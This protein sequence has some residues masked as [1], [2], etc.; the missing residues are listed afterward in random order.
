MFG[1]KNMIDISDF[2]CAQRT[3]VAKAEN[4]SQQNV[5]EYRF[6]TQIKLFVYIAVRCQHH[7]Q[8]AKAV[9]LSN[10]SW[11]DKTVFKPIGNYLSNDKCYKL[12]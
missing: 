4:D 2:S 12:R 9:P 11:N 10:A 8:T 7:W 1:A 5:Y 6:L 3:I